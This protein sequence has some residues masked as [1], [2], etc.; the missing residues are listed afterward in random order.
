MTQVPFYCA[1]KAALHSYTVSLRGQLA[2]MLEVIEIYPPSV[3]TEM[4][5]GVELRTIGVDDFIKELMPRLEK[6]EEEIWIGEGRYI[7]I[8]NR[9]APKKTL[10][11]V[12][13][14]TRFK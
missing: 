5:K 13:R 2:G 14:A 12:N 3:E 9:L 10:A 11:L 4:M 7:P 8:L 6:G 1:S